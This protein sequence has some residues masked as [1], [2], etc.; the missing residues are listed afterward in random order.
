MGAQTS[1]WCCAKAGFGPS[2]PAGSHSGSA[3]RL[4]VGRSLA[5]KP[6]ARWARAIR[7]T[8]D[9]GPHHLRPAPVHAVDQRQELRLSQ[10]D[11]A[12]LDPQPMQPMFV[13][14]LGE[15]TNARAILSWSEPATHNGVRAAKLSRTVGLACLQSSRR[16]CEL[17]ARFTTRRA[18]PT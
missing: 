9:A 1:A 12:V 18:D 17:M 6:A 3:P 13:E 15:Q 2:T 5:A 10:T 16:G 8:S 4:E 11:H 14:P 7:A